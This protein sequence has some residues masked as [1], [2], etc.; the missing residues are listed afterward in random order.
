MLPLVFRPANAHGS[1]QS[2]PGIVVYD[3][4]T[5]L[6]TEL[7]PDGATGYS[8]DPAVSPSGKVVS[9]TTWATCRP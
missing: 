8:R 9:W 3:R 4:A 6:P 5:G 1:D 2:R 7:T